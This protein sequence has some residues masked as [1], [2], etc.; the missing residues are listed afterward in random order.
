LTATYDLDFQ[1]PVSYGH[2]SYT[3]KNIRVKGRFFHKIEWKQTDGQMD[4]TDY[5]TFPRM[6]SVKW[7]VN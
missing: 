7:P 4:M 1:S 6:W 5:I 3:Y 2:D